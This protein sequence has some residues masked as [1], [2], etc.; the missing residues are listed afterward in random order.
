MHVITLH[1]YVLMQHKRIAFH[2]R[3]DLSKKVTVNASSLGR[4]V[5][6]LFV[7]LPYREPS[8]EVQNAYE[9]SNAWVKRVICL[10]LTY[11]GRSR[12]LSFLGLQDLFPQP[13]WSSIKKKRV[14]CFSDVKFVG[15]FL[16]SKPKARWSK[17]RR[18][19]GGVQGS[20]RACT[21][22]ECLF[23]RV[24]SVVAFSFGFIPCCVRVCA[25][26]KNEKKSSMARI[27]IAVSM[28]PRVRDILLTC[29]PFKR[30]IMYCMPPAEEGGPLNQVGPRNCP[31]M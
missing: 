3:T 7:S 2:V 21:K 24:G 23:A 14:V 27:M 9:W 28:A 17:M 26:S 25:Y 31:A 20:D 6:C 19:R 15:Y 8:R 1:L 10:P 11:Q 22:C 4:L 18:I 13:V 29:V 12:S 30:F 5:V 16:K